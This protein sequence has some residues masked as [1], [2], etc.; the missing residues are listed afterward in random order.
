MEFLRFISISY[1]QIKNKARITNKIQTTFVIR[2]FHL[3]FYSIFH[4]KFCVEGAFNMK[5]QMMFP[6]GIRCV[7]FSSTQSVFNLE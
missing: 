6:F 3:L 5:N 4:R 7:G 1:L 2:A